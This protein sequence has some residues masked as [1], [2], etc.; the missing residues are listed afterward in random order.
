M[1]KVFLSILSAAAF[2]LPVFS[3]AAPLTDTE[4]RWLKAGAPVLAYAKQLKLPIDIVVQPQAQ[5]GAVPLAMG[6]DGGRCK[7]VL[8][9]RDNPAAEQVLASV[10]SDQRG[11][12][13]EAM[14]AHEIGHCWRYAQ[15]SWHSVP[16]GFQQQSASASLPPDIQKLSEELG[17]TRLEEAYADLVALAWI[18]RSRPGEYAQVYGWL[19]QVR[20]A[21]PASH[22]SH[23]T[24]AWLALAADSTVFG[25]AATPF[26]QAR[27]VWDQGLLDAE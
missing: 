3:H 6:F 10:P 27:A 23:D 19:H 16:S 13:I 22:V 4:A 9:M 24:L 15:G 14:T 8:T 21:Q 7:L 12:M 5:P 20:D 11:L 18:K 2:G 26:D 1:P 17:A 25:D